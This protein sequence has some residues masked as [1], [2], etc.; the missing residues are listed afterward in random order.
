M[1]VQK[2]EDLIDKL[3]T[4]ACKTDAQSQWLRFVMG[5]L[6]FC[7]VAMLTKLFL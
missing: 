6:A 4:D 3:V 7:T 5:G 1:D 2:V